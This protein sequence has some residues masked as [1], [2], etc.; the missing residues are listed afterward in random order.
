MKKAQ[1][2]TPQAE[3]PSDPRPKRSGH[4]YH[5]FILKNGYTDFIDIISNHF[6]NRKEYIWRGQDDPDHQLISSL[7]RIIR[8]KDYGGEWSQKASEATAKHLSQ[9]LVR[10]REIHPLEIEHM[11]LHN[12]LLRLLTERPRGLASILYEID[13][14]LEPCHLPMVFEL[15]ALG[16]HNGLATPLLDWTRSPLIALWFA[17]LGNNNRPDGVGYRAVYAL[18]L[19]LVRQRWPDKEAIPEDGIHVLD[20]LTRQNKRIEAQEGVFTLSPSHHSIEECVVKHIGDKYHEEPVLLRF[21]I[22]N[23]DKKDCL[24]WLEK[25]HIHFRSMY[26]DISGAA[27]ACNY[28]LD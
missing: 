23:I 9:F 21:L 18:N 13:S 19:S 7:A 6:K 2:L 17:F 24:A 4:G 10:L 12:R 3:S 22:P 5:T 25:A 15:F 1:N 27:Q 11:V 20:V 14:E 28:E 16:Q 8:K 26:P